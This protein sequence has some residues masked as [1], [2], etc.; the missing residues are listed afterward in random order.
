MQFTASDLSKLLNGELIGDPNIKVSKVAKIEEATPG[1]VS[2]VANPKYEQHLYTT[3]AS[4]VIVNKTLTIKGNV[5]P[6]LIKVNDAYNCLSILLDKFHVNSRKIG[7]DTLAFITDS[8]K[9]AEK[10][11]IGPFAYI[12]DRTTLKSGANIYP[13]VYVGDNVSIGENTIIYP[14]AKIYDNCI[15]GDNCIIH[16]G[17][18]IGS[19]GFGFA[20]E[21]NGMYKKVAQTGNVVIENNVEIG[22]NTTIDRATMG[23]TLIK[24]GVKLDNLIQ[25]AHNVEIGENT[26]IAAQTGVSGS[27]KIGEQ[28]AIG[29][30]VGFVGHAYIAPNTKIGAQSGIPASIKTSGKVWHGS[31]VQELK[32]ELKSMVVYKKLPELLKRIEKLERSLKVA[33]AGEIQHAANEKEHNI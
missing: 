23:S 7:I 10:V 15:I 8:S 26:V 31:P 21:E 17:A 16:S 29:G 13:N 33:Q 6:A 27:T 14:G 30:Q 24:K 4:I 11:Y 12:G 25:V 3:N 5:S 20:P 32:D 22:A 1:T 19:D 28:C 9:I 18:V 2:F